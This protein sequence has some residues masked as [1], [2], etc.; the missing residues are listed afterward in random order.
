[1]W[2]AHVDRWMQSSRNPSKSLVTV[3][4]FMVWS[5]LQIHFLNKIWPTP[6]LKNYCM[7]IYFNICISVAKP[8]GRFAEKEKVSQE[9]AIVKER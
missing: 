9:G 3:W 4:G 7:C 5:Y 1:M 2:A 8:K 6:P